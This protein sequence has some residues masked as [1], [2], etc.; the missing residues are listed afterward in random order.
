MSDASRPFGRLFFLLPEKKARRLAREIKWDTFSGPVLRKEVAS[1]SSDFQKNAAGFL[2]LRAPPHSLG[3][4]TILPPNSLLTRKNTGNSRTFGSQE[5]QSSLVP[6]SCRWSSERG[7]LE[8]NRKLSR[9]NRKR[10][11]LFNQIS[12]IIPSTVDLC[13]LRFCSLPH[14]GRWER[15]NKSFTH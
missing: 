4:S 6:P 1:I 11:S 7:A 5:H 10:L 8:P 13:R 2:R 9:S 14:M 3:F 12:P 15:G